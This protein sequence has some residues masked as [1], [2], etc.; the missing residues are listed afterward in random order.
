MSRG[1]LGG[2]IITQVVSVILELSQS[3]EDIK[4][5]KFRAK[6]RTRMAVLGYSL[7]EQ[8][9]NLIRNVRLGFEPLG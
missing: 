6:D 5:L 1:E 4:Q 8:R 9:E 3:I 7:L 2:T